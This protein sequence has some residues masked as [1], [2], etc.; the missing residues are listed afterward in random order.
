MPIDKT[1]DGGS[2]MEVYMA[3]QW[4]LMWWRFR[5]H[6]MAVFSLILIMTMY[7]G[8]LFCEFLAPEDPRKVNQ[9]LVYAPPRRI[10]FLSQDGFHVRPFVYG[11]ERKRDPGTGNWVFT[12]DL[13][14][15]YPIR[16]VVQGDSYKMWGVFKSRLHL[17]GT[18]A[19]EPLILLGADSMGRDLLSRILYGSRISLSVGLL[20]VFMSMMLGILIGGLSGYL[21][22][23]V[24]LIV[25]RVIEVLRSMPTLPLWMGLSAAVPI[26]WPPVRVYFGITVILSIIGWTGLARV[27]RGKFIS[28]RDEEFVIAA[29]L[30]GAG[31]MRIIFRHLVPSFLSYLIASLTLS[32]PGMILGETSLSFLGIGLRPP[33]ISWG[34]LLQTAQ[35]L[36]SIAMASW[37]LYPALFLILTVLALNF[38]GDGVRDA[39]DPYGA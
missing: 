6:K 12:L 4:Q 36:R 11:Y 2:H 17:F 5:K 1:A 21:G 19:E 37:L 38:V 31:Q 26:D 16:F 9:H 3:S 23:V 29:R 24:D 18:D 15:R 10:R 14:R 33:A 22:G 8:A 32:I 27:V 25:Q 28:L 20:G 13:A 7:L 39:A 30:A 35:N 34:V